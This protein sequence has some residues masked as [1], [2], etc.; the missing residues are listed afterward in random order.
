MPDYF[1]EWEM[2]ID[3][4]QSPREAAQQAWEAMRRP[5]SSA[6]VFTVHDK[7]SGAVYHVDLDWE[8]M[9]QAQSTASSAPR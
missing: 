4:A 7:E 1:V 3:D 5:D 2:D 6:N 8:E 9:R